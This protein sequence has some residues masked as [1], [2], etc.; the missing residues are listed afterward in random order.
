MLYL[1]VGIE[2]KEEGVRKTLALK[3]EVATLKT[4]LKKILHYNSI[5]WLK[6]FEPKSR[7]TR[8]ESPVSPPSFHLTLVQYT[9]DTC[10]R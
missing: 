10:C 4:R 3:S 8:T 6:T 9:A 5:G 7:I 2:V 1:E